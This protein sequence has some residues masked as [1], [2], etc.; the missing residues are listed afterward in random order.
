[1]MS[2]IR[3]DFS[4]MKAENKLALLLPLLY[5]AMSVVN[6]FFRAFCILFVVTLVLS[7]M[8]YNERSGFERYMSAL[9]LGRRAAVTAR[10]AEAVGLTLLLLAAEFALSQLGFGET[11][12][13]SLTEA[14]ALFGMATIYIAV[15]LPFA[16]RLG[17]ERSRIT[18]MLGMV[19]IAAVFVSI[20]GIDVSGALPRALEIAPK[21]LA[22]LGMILVMVSYVLSVRFYERREF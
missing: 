3:S 6:M 22:T 21:L 16:F 4:I 10:Y 12:K 15:A 1:M 5:A 7:A 19:I 8:T 13:M 20:V 14:L 2:V 9:P 17:V 18:T 11:G